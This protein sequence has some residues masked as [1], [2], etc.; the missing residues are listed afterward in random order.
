[1]VA[2]FLL[3]HIFFFLS[4]AGVEADQPEIAAT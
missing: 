1:V 4:A 2:F 3:P